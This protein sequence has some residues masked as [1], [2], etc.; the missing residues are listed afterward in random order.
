MH[1]IVIK[2]KTVCCFF[3]ARV[4][5][6]TYL[7]PNLPYIFLQHRECLQMSLVGTLCLLCLLYNRQQQLFYQSRCS[8]LKLALFI[9]NAKKEKKNKYICFC[10]KVLVLIRQYLFTILITDLKKLYCILGNYIRQYA[11]WDL[12][13]VEKTFIGTFAG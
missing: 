9:R 13:K 2:M 11:E 4:Y 5:I 3:Q 12:N 10:Y 1:E 6:F 7:S 8:V